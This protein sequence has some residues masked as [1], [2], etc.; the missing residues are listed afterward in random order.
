MKIL[1]LGAVL[2]S[3]ICLLTMFAA[4]GKKDA[5]SGDTASD[6][7][8]TADVSFVNDGESVYMVVRAD[9]CDSRIAESASNVFRAIKKA[10]GVNAKNVSDETGDGADIPEI[11]IGDTNREASSLAKELLLSE[12][13]GRNDE[14]IIC[15]IKED[16]AIVGTCVESTIKAV[17]YFIET[18]V[19]QSTVAGGI[20]HI[21]SNP[22]KYSE[23][24]LFGK[25]NLYGVE[26]VRPIYNL[27]YVVQTEIDAMLDSFEEKSGYRFIEVNDNVAS[28]KGQK[29]DGSG[30]LTPTTPAEYE[31]IIDSSVRDGVK[32]ITNK[33]EHE[34]R[35]EDK[36]AY[37]NG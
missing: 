26:L 20:Y 35:I 12:A 5:E 24:A 11:L 17:D 10:H 1:R 19:S 13:T 16:I 2:L 6:F 14:F 22:E 33:N 34:L 18:Y 4:C 30:T 21:N 37:L 25:T 23:V 8:S 31:I 7:L 15:T 29:L 3:L 9:N 28:N 32:P 27:S 36:K